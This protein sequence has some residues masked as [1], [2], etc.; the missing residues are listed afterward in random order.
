MDASDKDTVYQTLEGADVAAMAIAR[1]YTGNNGT[2]SLSNFGA[3]VIA[4]DPATNTYYLHIVDLKTCEVPLVEEV[5]NGFEYVKALPFF[6]YFEGTECVYGFSFADVG[7]ANSFAAA[8]KRLPGV[9]IVEGT[10]SVDTSRSTASHTPVRNTPPPPPPQTH[11]RTPPPPPQPRAA[12]AAAPAPAP[13]AEPIE[14]STATGDKMRNMSSVSLGGSSSSKK[15]EKKEEKKEKPAKK[16]RGFFS[17]LFHK[18]EEEDEEN[19]EISNPSGFSHASHIGFD[20]ET[21]GFDTKNIPPEW[22]KLFQA[23]GIRK[24]DLKDAETCAALVQIMQ[25]NDASAPAAPP[26][27]PAPAAPSCP[28]APPAPPAPGAP[29]PPP[30]P[31]A[32]P[33]PPAPGAPPPPRAPAAPA[34]PGGGAPPPPRPSPGGDRGN[35]LDEIQRGKQL[36]SVDQRAVSELHA[37]S[38]ESNEGQSM[39]AK[40]SQVMNIRRAAIEDDDDDD[41]NDEWSD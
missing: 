15:E 23:A 17:S 14:R 29:P 13:A 5:Y 21:G 18:D 38:V 27:P 24:K 31:P 3:A 8:V 28:A 33:P 12:P 37:P 39:I 20:A 22:K 36:R 7:E 1:L 10:G 16:K 34:A 26:A 2:W 30:A 41:D 4:G 40:L 11:T 32:P 35:L 6:H 25:Q 9:K 19:F